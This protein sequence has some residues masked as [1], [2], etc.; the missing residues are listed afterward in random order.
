MG[1]DYKENEIVTISLERYENLKSKIKEYEELIIR[2]YNCNKFK[3]DKT[4]L[5][6]KQDELLDILQECHFMITNELNLSSLFNNKDLKIEV[7]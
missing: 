7:I 1:E 2:L 3:N 4:I 5:V 6:I